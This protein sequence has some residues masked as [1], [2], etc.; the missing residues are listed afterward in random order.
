MLYA[1]GWSA[2]NAGRSSFAR[3]GLSAMPSIEL[4][5][6]VRTRGSASPTVCSTQQQFAR[7]Q[8]CDRSRM[9][10]GHYRDRAA[11]RPDQVRGQRSDDTVAGLHRGAHD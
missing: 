6:S 9:R 1:N 10:L 8:T 3:P 7:W 4:A 5:S 2:A 11:C